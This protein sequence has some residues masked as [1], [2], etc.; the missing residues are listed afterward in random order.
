MMKR[1]AGPDRFRDRIKPHQT[2]AMW[3]LNGDLNTPA[4]IAY[5]MKSQM[6][7][8]LAVGIIAAR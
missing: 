1:R 4:D 7:R 2:S 5:I 3:Y 8:D 6:L